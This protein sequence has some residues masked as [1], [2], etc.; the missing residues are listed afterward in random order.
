MHLSASGEMSSQENLI[1]LISV[2]MIDPLN[3]FSVM[4][5]KINSNDP[6]V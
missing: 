5:A 1:P 6:S 2:E 4:L 3:R